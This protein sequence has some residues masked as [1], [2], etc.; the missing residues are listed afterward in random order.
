MRDAGASNI[1]WVF[2]VN[3]GDHPSNDWNRLEQ[4]YPGSDSID[5]L[6]V[7]VYGAQ[8]PQDKEWPAFRS[9]M[10]EVY[11][12]LAKLDPA[13]PILVLEMGV[14]GRHPKVRKAD[15]T[16]NALT[17]LMASRWPKTAG[18][19]WWNEAWQNDDNGKN[20]TNMRVQDDP[21]T[22]KVFQEL[23]GKNPK[24]LDRLVIR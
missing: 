10:D 4:Y 23:V 17:D 21:E 8:S 14:T 12:R 16:Q 5:V 13:K 11:P 18:F 7:S 15:W 24:V 6:G 1:L 3:D 22:T 19:A 2:H 9:G 20:D